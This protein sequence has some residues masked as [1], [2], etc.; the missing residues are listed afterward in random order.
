[1]KKSNTPNPTVVRV[2]GWMF[3]LAFVVPTLNWALVLSGFNVAGDALATA[4]N[5]M[6]NEFAFRA[7]ISIELLMAL[8]L[9]LLGLSLYIILKGI[10][11]NIALFALILK[12][13]EATLLAITV[14]VPYIALQLLNG[15]QG[16]TAFSREQMQF[17]LGIIFNSHMAIT[18]IPMVFLGLDM[19]LFSYLFYRSGYIPR[20]LAGFGIVSFALIF[21]QSLLFLLAPD[22][23]EIPINQIIF[24]GPS[25]LFEILIGVWLL[26]KGV[27]IPKPGKLEVS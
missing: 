9:L 5:I 24:W 4:Q 13:V 21:I 16:L 27:D 10:N 7:G 19:M 18:A 3:L 2:A 25:G 20:L 1:M 15:D 23:A 17:P 6:A 8:S 14:L 12:L 22:Y 11:K 26:V